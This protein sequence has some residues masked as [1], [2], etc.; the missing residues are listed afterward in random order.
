[1]KKTVVLIVSVTLCAALLI[2]CTPALAVTQSPISKST[3]AQSTEPALTATVPV[4]PSAGTQCSICGDFDCDDGAFC[5]DWD[6][7]AENLREQENIRNDPP[8]NICGEYDCDDGAFC[9]DWDDR[10]E[11]ND[12]HK[13]RRRHHS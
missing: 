5:D 12:D 1:M 2:G 3:L 10:R 6:E 11:H 7:K 8:C 13:H 9:D 4:T